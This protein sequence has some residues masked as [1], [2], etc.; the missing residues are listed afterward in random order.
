MLVIRDLDEYLQAMRDVLDEDPPKDRRVPA[1]VRCI[2]STLLDAL[3]NPWQPHMC[4]LWYTTLLLGCRHSEVRYLRVERRGDDHVI[5]LWQP[6]TREHRVVRTSL[7][8]AA[9]LRALQVEVDTYGVPTRNSVSRWIARR[10]PHIYGM[11]PK[12]IHRGSHLG[13]HIHV[14]L[15]ASMWMWDRREISA[16][17][18]V[19]PDTV[20]T[21]TALLGP[22]DLPLIGW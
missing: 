6:K 16:H 11:L 5:T 22:E 12:G 9:I 18:A 3:A 14:A 7:R 20:R 8:G 13:R 10:C 2:L 4:G 17:M 21:Y 15:L 1:R 19:S